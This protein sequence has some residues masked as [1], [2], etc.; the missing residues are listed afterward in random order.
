MARCVAVMGTAGVGK[1]TLVRGLGALLGASDG[2]IAVATLTAS[3]E[4][5]TL[6]D[7]PGAAEFVGDANAALLAA[8]AAVI[9]V[10]PHPEDAPLA[11]PYLRAVEAA[12]TPAI[13][14]VNRMDEARAAARDTVA[15]L[16]D[17]ARHTLILRQIPMREG[18]RVVGAVDLISERAWRYRE[19]GPSALVAMPV[20]L[21]EREHADRDAMLESLSDYDDW[22]LEEIVED[23][24]PDAA[25]VYDICARVLR[26]NRAISALIGSAQHGGGMVRLLKALRHETPG[27]EALRARLADGGPA[28][29][30]VCFGTARRAHVG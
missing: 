23:H 27:P 18:E 24:H 30:A 7:C 16:Q 22:L 20:E 11:A 1:T 5:W 19:G 8:D 6:L 13:L 29:E 12:G 4:T 21:T 2:R 10:S 17:Y 9:V 26:E 25:P 14:F 3:G 15:A 28:P